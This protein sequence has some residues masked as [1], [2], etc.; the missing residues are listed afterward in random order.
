M[1][2][3]WRLAEVLRVGAGFVA[4]AAGWGSDRGAGAGEASEPETDL[5]GAG[6]AAGSAPSLVRILLTNGGIANNSIR[7]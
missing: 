6:A 2:S 7:R 1:K 4:G 3:A 5:A